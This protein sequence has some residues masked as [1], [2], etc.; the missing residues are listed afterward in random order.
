MAS[1]TDM[2]DVEDAYTW[3]GRVQAETSA[4][5]GSTGCLTL[6]QNGLI[7]TMYNESCEVPQAGLCEHRGKTNFHQ[8]QNVQFFIVLYKLKSSLLH[9]T[10]AAVS[11][12]IQVQ[13]FHKYW[14]S[15]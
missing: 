10:W 6:H 9:N 3:E 8:D 4:K 5:T 14:D 12:P 13:E 15:N 11:I 2:V 7:H 1:Y